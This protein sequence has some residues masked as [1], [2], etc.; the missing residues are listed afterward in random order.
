MKKPLLIAG[1]H[2]AAPWLSTY[3]LNRAWEPELEL[4][5]DSFQPSW[6]ASYTGFYTL[7]GAFE[8]QWPLEWCGQKIDGW[9]EFQNC[10]LEMLSAIKIHILDLHSIR[11]EALSEW[12][13]KRPY[14]PVQ[15]AKQQETFRINISWDATAKQ[16]TQSWEQVGELQNAIVPAGMLTVWKS[17]SG[18]KLYLSAV[19]PGTA[20]YTYTCSEK[21]EAT[22]D[23]IELLQAAFPNHHL[24]QN[25]IIL[26]RAIQH[27]P[28]C[29]VNNNCFSILIP[30]PSLTG[31]NILMQGISWLLIQ[32]LAEWLTEGLTRFEDLGPRS[33]NLLEKIRSGL[34]SQHQSNKYLRILK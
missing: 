34:H 18:G 23:F 4:H 17:K 19:K 13:Q 5:N 1:N 22:S 16:D 15:S 11:Q 7:F 14:N 21:A 25:K 6:A 27:F 32:S 31:Q 12:Y 26:R 30:R 8:P 2:P 24:P 28:Y 29:T 33:E 3:L 20:V 9:A 10:E